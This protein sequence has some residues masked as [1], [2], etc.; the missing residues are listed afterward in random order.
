MNDRRLTPA[1]D[2]VAA[3]RLRGQVEAETYVEG[4]RYSVNIPVAGL[5]KS[6]GGARDRQVL[7]GNSVIVYEFHAGYAFVETAYD[8]YVGYIAEDAIGPANDA[9]HSVVQL[10]TH[11]YPKADLKTHEIAA[12][13]FGSQTRIIGEEGSFCK[14]DTGHFIPKQHLRPIKETA[15]DPVSVAELFLGTP[16][17]WGGNSAWGIDC[18]G[19]VQAALK[20]CGL[21]CP[22]DS[23]LQE[24]ALGQPMKSNTPYQRGD[25]LFWKGHVAMAVDAETLIHA[26]GYSMSVT[27][28]NIQSTI[29]RIE[30]QG[31]G[32]LTS[33]RRIS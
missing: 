28:E 17:L 8:G 14:T 5:L 20:T 9:T 25:F 10:S 7:Y 22:G 29:K 31:E 15:T 4:T 18:S 23:D 30:A 6:P 32:P 21:P 19:L 3:L 27:L 24:K 33:H 16:Y 11:T 12:L 13:S 1:N 2:R 26:N